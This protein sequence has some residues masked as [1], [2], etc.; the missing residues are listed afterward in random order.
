MLKET[1]VDILSRL[2]IEDRETVAELTGAL[3]AVNVYRELEKNRLR[4]EQGESDVKVGNCS[5]SS[6]ENLVRKFR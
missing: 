1:S 6:R 3:I 4:A 2:S 5:C